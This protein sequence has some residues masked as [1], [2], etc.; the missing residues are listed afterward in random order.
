MSDEFEK[1]WNETWMTRHV[2]YP[3][4]A[5]EEDDP[6]ESAR[7]G[8]SEATR[9]AEARIAVLEEAL[10]EVE[11]VMGGEEPSCPWCRQSK[12][13]GHLT[14]CDREAALRAAQGIG[15][16]MNGE[17]HDRDTMVDDQKVAKPPAEQF[18]LVLLTFCLCAKCGYGMEISPSRYDI[19]LALKCPNKKC[20]VYGVQYKVPKFPVER[21]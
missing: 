11:W 14:N 15:G 2:K 6:K 10:Q 8:W 21:V 17:V 16:A 1:W 4:L 5:Q 19:P 13:H 7:S 20:E 9:Q 12:R 18:S 3:R